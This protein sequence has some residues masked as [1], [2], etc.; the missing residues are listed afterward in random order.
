MN[1]IGAAVGVFS[2]P[3]TKSEHDRAKANSPGAN[4]APGELM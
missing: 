4:V 3:P 1:S 2:P